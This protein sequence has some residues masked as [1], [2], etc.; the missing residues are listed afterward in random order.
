MPRESLRSEG[1]IEG[2]TDG[3][4]DWFAGSA[5]VRLHALPVGP[6]IKRGRRELRSVVTLDNSR[7]GRL[8]TPPRRSAGVQH[9]RH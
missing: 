7:A 8:H 2:F 1:A 5:E 4:I 9:Q 6:V 3:V